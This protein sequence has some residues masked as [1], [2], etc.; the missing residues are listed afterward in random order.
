MA[1]APTSQAAL[2]TALTTE[3]CAL[4]MHLRELEA[5]GA[6]KRMVYAEVLPLRVE[7]ELTKTGRSLERVLTALY[8]WGAEHRAKVNGGNGAVDA[9]AGQV[10][11][12]TTLNASRT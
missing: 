10:M 12:Q 5:D 3:H 7:Y 9:E 6:I 4:T 8:D 11:P 2:L 1:D